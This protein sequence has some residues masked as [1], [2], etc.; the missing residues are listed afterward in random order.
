MYSYVAT[1]ESR[2][3]ILESQLRVSQSHQATSRNG[4]CLTPETTFFESQTPE[5]GIP[6]L[7]QQDGRESHRDPR[8]LALASA[9]PPNRESP[10]IFAKS[11]Q[12]PGS[13]TDVT[14]L[15]MVY[16]REYVS[17][18]EVDSLPPL[19]SSS[20]AKKL[21]DAAYFYTQARYCIVDWTQLGIWHQQRE[22]IAQVS[23]QSPVEAQ[24]GRSQPARRQNAN[25]NFLS[26]A[27]FIWIVYA[28]GARL[29]PD[30]ENST[31]AWR[32]RLS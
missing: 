4:I 31:E 10:E 1:L 13:T 11:I 23:P 2:I 27:F 28:I 9:Q 12:V 22:E 30:S 21:V 5:T 32:A 19:P 25:I 18:P 6:T 29:I 24:T 16:G 3:Q 8:S 7:I 14:M 15:E 20:G 17:E 26:G